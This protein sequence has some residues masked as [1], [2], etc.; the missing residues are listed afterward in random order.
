M[1]RISSLD[2]I[3][4]RENQT[5]TRVLKVQSAGLIEN[6]ALEVK[7]RKIHYGGRYDW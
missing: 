3:R 6:P 2:K 1:W 4:T 5:W 7:L